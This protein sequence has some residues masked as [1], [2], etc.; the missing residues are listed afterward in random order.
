MKIFT[1]A[2]TRPNFIKVDPGLKQTIVNTGQHYDRNMS[3]VFF[4]GFKPKYNLKQTTVG[5]MIDELRKILAKNQPDLVIVFGDTNSSLAGALAAAYEKIPVCHIEAGLRSYTNMP[6]EINRK[7]IDRLAKVLICPNDIAEANLKKEG[8]V[9][10]VY[11]V[12]DPL[13]D[14]LMRYIPIVK[15]KDYQKYILVTLHRENNANKEFVKKFMDIL[16]GTD[17]Q[18]IF[19]AHPRLKNIL[20]T[21]PKNV[22]IIEPV[23]YEEMLKLESNALKIITDSGG[24]QRE[25]AWFNVPVIVM[26]NETEWLN[27]IEQGSIKLSNLNTLKY[28]IENFKGAVV[29]APLPGVNKRI[30]EI[31][32]KYL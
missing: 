22:K 29:A 4:N 12:G 19:P 8:I 5:G 30:R 27:L 32:F 14:A 21:K 23:D 15:S 16:G 13:S 6:E 9:N 10:D 25:G 20:T 3:S 1:I 24:V 2:G 31:I 17:Y 11:V 7:I 26:R 28:D 18:Y